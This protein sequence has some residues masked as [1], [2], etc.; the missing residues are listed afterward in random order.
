MSPNKEEKRKTPNKPTTP[1]N[2]PTKDQSQKLTEEDLSRMVW[3]QVS[4]EGFDSDDGYLPPYTMCLDLENRRKVSAIP[5]GD[6]IFPKNF[7]ENNYQK[8]SETEKSKESLP[9]F[10]AKDLPKSGR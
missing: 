3:I 9:S 10:Q 5:T 6:L 1:K 7:I 2:S 4:E 8:K